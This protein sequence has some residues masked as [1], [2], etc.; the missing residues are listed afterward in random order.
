MTWLRAIAAGVFVISCLA[1]AGC[2][3]DTVSADGSTADITHRD[4]SFDIGS[5]GCVGMFQC[6]CGEA[7]CVG[8]QW[9]CLP[10]PDM[11][12]SDGPQPDIGQPDSGQDDSQ[13]GG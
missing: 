4:A 12:Q 8:G 9:E 6:I 5:N 11:G 3:D 13:A 7:V 1:G 10:C 2:G